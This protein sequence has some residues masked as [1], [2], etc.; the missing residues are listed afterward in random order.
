MDVSVVVPVRNGA[1]F[2][3]EAIASALSQCETRLVVV[4]DDG[5][6]DNTAEIVRAINDSR[7]VMVTGPA[8]GVSAARNLGLAAVAEQRGPAPEAEGWVVF[9]DADDRLRPGA[10][11]ALLACIEAEC[12]A[13]YGDYDRIDEEGRP[14]GR[15]RLLLNRRKPSGDILEK[16]LAGNFLVNGGV[17]L[18][19]L[20]VMRQLRGFDES[21]RHCEDWH[22]FCR[23]AARGRIIWRPDAHVLDY[24][25]H[26]GSTMMNSAINADSYLL[27]VDRVFSDP[28]MTERF[29]T[30]R[31]AEL[32]RISEAHMRTY[33][34]CQWLRAG[35][36]MRAIKEALRAVLF[37]PSA[38]PRV[39]VRLIGTA[40]G[41]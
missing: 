33:L 29:S 6:T 26:R 30:E 3:G 22:A 34:A 24:R 7:V 28:Q 36:Y 38:A 18:I 9:L 13:V 25:V 14:I 27:A 40:A 15:R 31:K 23:L 35:A 10:V 11:A 32:R 21:L 17:M 5:S 4:V 8:R 12:V 16:L 19:R 2:I 41:L 37:L 20:D 39:F 1:R